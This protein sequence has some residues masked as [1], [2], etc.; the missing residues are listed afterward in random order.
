MNKYHFNFSNPKSILATIILIVFNKYPLFVAKSEKMVIPFILH[1]AKY[2]SQINA[3]INAI[4]NEKILIIENKFIEPF[5]YLNIL[6]CVA[7][8]HVFLRYDKNV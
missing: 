4:C 7:Y 1:I 2:E 5:K 6:I 3:K 8:I